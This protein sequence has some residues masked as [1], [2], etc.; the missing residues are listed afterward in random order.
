MIHVYTIYK[1]IIYIIYLFIY[2]YIAYT[3]KISNI[4]KAGILAEIK[5]PSQMLQ[6]QWTLELNHCTRQTALQYTKIIL[7]KYN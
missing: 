1:N 2:I 7:L 5:A 4:S 6:A 3:Q